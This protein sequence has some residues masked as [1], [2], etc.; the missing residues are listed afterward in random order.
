MPNYINIEE[1]RNEGYLHE[2][3]RLFLH[4]LGL[5]LEVVVDDNGEYTLGGIWDYREDAEGITYAPETLSEEKVLNIE[6]IIQERY[7]A[8]LMA[9]GYWIQGVEG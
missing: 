6:K 7:Q 8:R 3:N 1:F 5:A 4:P 9:L 2:L